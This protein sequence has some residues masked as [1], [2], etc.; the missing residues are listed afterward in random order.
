MITL[1]DHISNLFSVLDQCLFEKSITTFEYL[2]SK[3][4]ILEDIFYYFNNH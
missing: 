4:K 3:N 2:D 1:Q